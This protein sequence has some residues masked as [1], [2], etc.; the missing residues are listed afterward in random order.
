MREETNFEK[1]RIK[2]LYNRDYPLTGP[3]HTIVSIF[4]AC[5]AHLATFPRLHSQHTP[6][7]FSPPK[8]NCL[9]HSRLPNIYDMCVTARLISI[10]LRIEELAFA[11]TIVT[12]TEEDSYNT[13][14]SLAVIGGLIDHYLRASDKANS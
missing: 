10:L 6:S 2:Y 3:S 7:K 1:L 12:D 4:Y 14:P 11:G 8:Q 9:R 13:D 5:F